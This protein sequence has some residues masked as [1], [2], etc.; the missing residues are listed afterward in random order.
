M[1][2]ELIENTNLDADNT[3]A[4]KIAE[5]QRKVEK[6][7]TFFKTREET[8]AWLEKMKIKNYEIDDNLVVNVQGSV[9]LDK[10]G[11]EYLPVQFGH[12]GDYFSC[13]GNKLLSLKGCP[14]T[15]EDS[16]DCAY[17]KLVT[18]E[19]FPKEIGS[20]CLINNNHLLTLE[21]CTENIYG[22][23]LCHDNELTSLLHGPK[24][25]SERYHC[26]KNKLV[27]MSG[28]AKVIGA[29]LAC[30]NNPLK[31]LEGVEEIGSDLSCQSTELD[32][33][34]IDWSKIKVKRF[35]ILSNR[36]DLDYM[37]AYV[38]QSDHIEMPYNKFVQLLNLKK[39]NDK[40]NTDL[41]ENNQLSSDCSAEESRKLKI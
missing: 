26:F 34:N 30:S 12:V 28:V 39:L 22:R 27:N 23:F 1:D 40:L 10:K 7:H 2:M 16:M 21:Y 35:I 37:N 38:N 17:N 32:L 29:N 31:T 14:H 20:S 4:V 15:V 41:D 19:Y 33:N 11:L 5:H 9:N 36:A 6:E 13:R 25:V 3:I 8:V 24:T 18:L